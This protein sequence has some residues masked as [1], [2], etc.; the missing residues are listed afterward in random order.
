[1]SPHTPRPWS[2]SVGEDVT[3]YPCF[4][5]GGLCGEEKRDKALIESIRVLIQAAPE[6]RDFL[7]DCANDPYDRVSGGVK[8]SA[9][10]ILKIMGEDPD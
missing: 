9:R 6:M 7:L 10:A 3:G 8:A 1:M 4:F 2:V 5:V